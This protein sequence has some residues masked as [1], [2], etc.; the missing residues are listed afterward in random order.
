MARSPTSTF[1]VLG[2]LLVATLAQAAPAEVPQAGSSGPNMPP[3]QDIVPS[4][5]RSQEPAV[6]GS[7]RAPAEPGSRS[8]WHDLKRPPVRPPIRPPGL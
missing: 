3:V 5:I 6:T 4:E 8:R 7:P 2:A 1:V